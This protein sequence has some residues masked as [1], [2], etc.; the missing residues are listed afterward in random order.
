MRKDFVKK[1]NSNRKSRIYKKE[2]PASKESIGSNLK[3]YSAG[4]ATGV[5]ISLLVYLLSLPEDK[6][7]IISEPSEP[8]KLSGQI[9]TKQKTTQFEFYEILPEK[10]NKYRKSDLS[11]ARTKNID[12]DK[13][14]F[15]QAGAFKKR[16]DAENRRV[17][18]VLLDLEPEISLTQE[19]NDSLYKL[20]VGPLRSLTEAKKVQ[21]LIESDGIKTLLK[22]RVTQ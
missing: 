4:T 7:T 22:R 20:T 17:K 5:V 2:S 19:K 21:K 6:K 1:A 11:T 8:K 15:L 13:I 14:Y 10:E 3:W 18:L 9:S 12:E 16:E